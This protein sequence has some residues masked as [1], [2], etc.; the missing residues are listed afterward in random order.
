M[1]KNYSLIITI[2]V[3]IFSYTNVFSQDKWIESFDSQY[4]ALPFY[5]INKMNSDK[6]NLGNEIPTK[7]KSD[8]TIEMWIN[9]NKTQNEYANILD[10]DHEYNKGLVIQQ[11][12]NNTNEYSFSIGSGK[13][14]SAIKYKFEDGK[15]QHIIFSRSYDYIYLYVNYYMVD[16]KPCF[17]EN[18]IYNTNANVTVGY[19]DNFN[20]RDFNGKICGIKLYNYSKYMNYLPKNFIDSEINF[21]GTTDGIK[22]RKNL[23]TYMDR[24]FRIETWIKPGK[25]QQKY[26]TIIDFNH[27][28]NSGLVIQQDSGNTNVYNLNISNGKISS[29][30]GCQL[31]SDVW[32]RVAFERKNNLLSVYIN[33]ILKSTKECFVEKIKFNNSTDNFTIGYNQNYGRN[34]NGDI[35]GF[36]ILGDYNNLEEMI[37][38]NDAHTKF[39]LDSNISK[40]LK[41]DFR[42]EMWVNPD[43][44]QEKYANIL[45]V[46]HREKAGLVIQQDENNLNKFNLG[47]SNGV[48]TSGVGCTLRANN[49]Q[50][51]IFERKGSSL[52][53]Y[54]DNKEVSSTTCF[55][56]DIMYLNNSD[57]T[58]GYNKNYGR[59]FSGLICGLKIKSDSIDYCINNDY[60]L[61]NTF[62]FN[63]KEKG[64]N[65][66]SKYISVLNS[67]QFSLSMWI[68][69]NDNQN[70]YSNILDFDH[71][72]NTGFVIQQDGN[73]NNKFSFGMGNGKESCSITYQ[74]KANEWQLVDFIR[75]NNVIKLYVNKNLVE[76]KTCFNDKIKFLDNANMTIGYNKNYGRIYNGKIKGLQINNYIP[77][78][79]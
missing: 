34:F 21:N 61:I 56:D 70:E 16:I 43:Q 7:M 2:L 53:C 60:N 36:K 38:L 45:D 79:K 74:F 15:W 68:N 69:P 71:R 23:I 54:L 12:G 40:Y 19:N 57:V 73:N 14:S 41:K 67:N 4:K 78:L 22:F 30:I 24:N 29:S 75:D 17:S 10:F 76:T 64:I 48:T 42:I 31:E 49:W 52:K 25:I 8:F 51:L 28:D 3:M 39:N 72:P 37:Q 6:M 32:Q 46:N 20:E 27:S 44:E 1:K 59:I 62:D 18:V 33:G 9:P 26:S 77:I 63:G 35:N 5:E 13:E 65:T 66:G 50:L 47:I 11:V 58:L 55:T